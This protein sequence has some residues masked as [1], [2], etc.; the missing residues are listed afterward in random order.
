MA[1]FT[2]N[3][4]REWSL[5]IDI[6]LAREIRQ[7]L[8]VDILNFETG[9]PAISQDP[10]LLCDVLY[11]LCRKQ[12][13]QRKIGDEDFGRGLVG[14]AIGDA[15]DAFVEALIN[16]SP[17]RR[18]KILTTMQQTA[19]SLETMLAGLAETKIPTAIQELQQ[20]IGPSGADC[21]KSSPGSPGSSATNRP[22]ASA[23]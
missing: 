20:L 5:E 14:D 22:A 10:I 16:F 21:G 12:A 23:N 7:R 15:C 8:S 3:K 17:S 1:K 4:Q 13:E 11:L 6:P 19:V 9:L 18:R 2:D